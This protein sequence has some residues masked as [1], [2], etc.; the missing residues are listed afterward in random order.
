MDLSSRKLNRLPE[1]L[2]SFFEIKSMGQYPTQLSETLD[3]TMDL[4]R[5]YAD[6]A[7]E[8]G[9]CTRVPFVSANTAAG[10]GNLTSAGWIAGGGVDFANGA[11]VTQVPQNE[12]WIILEAQCRWDFT[13]TAAQ[14]IAITLISPTS[15]GNTHCVITD[16]AVQGYLLSSATIARSGWVVAT[17]PFFALPGTLLQVWLAG[18]LV[19]GGQIDLNVSLRLRRLRL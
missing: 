18:A 3:G 16:S 19:P 9:C 7:S 17:K 1:G 2:L 8:H 15:P 4:F 12:V 6:R 5:W 13:A 10:V 14:E 11:A